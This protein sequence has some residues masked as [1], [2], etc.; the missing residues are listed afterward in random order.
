MSSD[1]A[2]D[3]V[4][5]LYDQATLHDRLDAAVLPDW[6]ADHYAF[7]RESMLDE[8]GF[9]CYFGV[10]SERKGMALYTFCESTTD[11]AALYR[12]RD[13]LLEYLDTYEGHSERASLVTCFRPPEQDLDYDGYFQ[14]FWGVLQ[15]LHE[16]DPVAWPADIPADPSHPQ[17]EWCFGGEP[18][19]PTVRAPCFEDRRSRYSPH[20]LEITF[21]PRSIFEGITGDTEAGRQARETIRT[22]LESYDAVC[23]HADLGSWED[24]DSR[25]WKQYMLPEDPEASHRTCPFEPRV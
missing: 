4:H 22:R 14:R 18:I 23:P 5:T 7:F 8:D 3:P 21:Q 24:D 25:E 19:F 15:Y 16:A 11:A 20:G 13:T 2:S 1:A 17:F 9:P 12:L 10:E 6:A